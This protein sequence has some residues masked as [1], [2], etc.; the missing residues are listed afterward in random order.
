[1]TDLS[2]WFLAPD[3]IGL[4]THCIHGLRLDGNPNRSISMQCSHCADDAQ[5]VK[6]GFL[7]RKIL[8]FMD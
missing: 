6:F 4:P 7:P 3:R 8:P 5:R 2:D 1:M